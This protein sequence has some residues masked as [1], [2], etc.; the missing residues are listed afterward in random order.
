[1]T[2]FSVKHIRTY[3]L[4]IALLVEAVKLQRY[5]L[6]LNWPLRL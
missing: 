6:E 3:P 1:M 5:I 4:S 2:F